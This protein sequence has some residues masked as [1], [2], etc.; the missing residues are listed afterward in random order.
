MAHVAT[1]G[2]AVELVGAAH[3]AHQPKVDV[4][5]DAAIPCI[6][7]H[8]IGRQDQMG[9]ALPSISPDCPDDQI[10]VAI[11]IH[12]PRRG[13]RPARIVVRRAAGELVRAIYTSDPAQVD[14][15]VSN[16]IGGIQTR[17]IVVENQI[18]LAGT[19]APAIGKG[20]PDDQIIATIAIHIPRRRH[21]SA[22]PV[23]TQVTVELVGGTGAPDQ[24]QVDVPID[25]A[26]PCIRRRQIGGK[27]QIGFARTD[28]TIAASPCPD[29]QIV[30][31]IAIN[32]PRRGYRPT[33]SVSC[34]IAREMIGS[35]H[36]RDLTKVDHPIRGGI[37]RIRRRQIG[38]KDQIG[39]AGI[40]NPAI[41]KGRPNQQIVQTITINITSRGDRNTSLVAPCG[42]FEL[43]S[44]KSTSA[45]RYLGI[46]KIN[47]AIGGAIRRIRQCQ[48]SAIQQIGLARCARTRIMKRSRPDQ[49]I[50]NA[51]AIN[52]TSRGDTKTSLA[53]CI[54]A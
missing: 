5:I 19:A 51:I 26:I 13:Y 22:S 6:R 48:I 7:R 39:R 36:T 54:G 3:T 1:C 11:A 28:V 49:Q 34:R 35:A 32:I 17:K 45:I 24:A 42:A 16:S 52:I 27:D 41:G 53:V 12:I 21:G 18:G 14:H 44:Y 2:T 38:G 25:A 23:M 20:C 15:P 9:L 30:V 8:Q 46:I 10:V 40:D 4:P 31:A 29:Q 50:G 47:H 33:S 43:I 37:R